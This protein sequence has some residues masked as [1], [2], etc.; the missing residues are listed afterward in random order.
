MLSILCAYCEE[1]YETADESRGR[2]IPCPACGESNRALGPEDIAE[3]LNAERTTQAMI[4][5]EVPLPQE[6]TRVEENTRRLQQLSDLLLVFGYVQ[7]GLLVVVGLTPLASA[8]ALTWKLLILLV[9]GL[10][11]TVMF[12]TFR[13]L[14]ELTAALATMGEQQAATR[15][16][17]RELLLLVAR[18]DEL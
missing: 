11:A 10:L 3:Q 6:T 15:E 18:D 13:F 7:A 4:V 16:Q 8:L 5:A 14:A 12:V 1:V 17:L 9:A 2:E